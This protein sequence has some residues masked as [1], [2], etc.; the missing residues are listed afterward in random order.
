MVH[1][2]TVMLAFNKLI[3][4]A[5]PSW[6]SLG[7]RMGGT[8]EYVHI[9]T[10]YDFITKLCRQKAGVIQKLQEWKRLEHW[11]RRSPTQKITWWWSSEQSKVTKKSLYEQMSWH[12]YGLIC[13]TGYAALRYKPEGRGFDSRWGHWDFSLTKSFRPQYG[14]RVNSVSNR[15]E[16]QGYLLGG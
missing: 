9:L 11:T 13:F 10:M 16:Y 7:H 4:T 15:N 5:L 8:Y 1:G 14:P 2:T 3:S 12:N 6:W